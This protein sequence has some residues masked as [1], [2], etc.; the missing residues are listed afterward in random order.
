MNATDQGRALGTSGHINALCSGTLRGE[1]TGQMGP[2]FAAITF[3]PHYGGMLVL[4]SRVK[5]GKQVHGLRHGHGVMTWPE[6]SRPEQR[7]S[8]SRF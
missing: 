2:S 7:S 4:V 3:L 5:L 8:C 1:N 6:G